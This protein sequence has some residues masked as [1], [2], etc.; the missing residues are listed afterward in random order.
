MIISVVHEM[1]K[2]LREVL[3]KLPKVNSCKKT[4]LGHVVLKGA[5]NSVL[6]DWF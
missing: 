6:A 3:L 5:Y 1:N 4:T 2:L